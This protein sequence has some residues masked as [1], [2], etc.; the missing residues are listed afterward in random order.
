MTSFNGCSDDKSENFLQ[1]CF[2]KDIAES[3]VGGLPVQKTERHY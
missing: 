2:E 3:I 1:Q